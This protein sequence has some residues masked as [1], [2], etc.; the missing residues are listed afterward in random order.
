M[1]T[2][3]VA[4]IFVGSCL[5]GSEDG[6]PSPKQS[7]SQIA[8]E[9]AN[10]II[11]FQMELPFVKWSALRETRA[12]THSKVYLHNSASAFRNVTVWPYQLLT[13]KCG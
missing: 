5:Y 12:Y 10:S 6:S 9:A 4:Y 13:L 1:T 11:R 7:P 3:T 8:N 2:P